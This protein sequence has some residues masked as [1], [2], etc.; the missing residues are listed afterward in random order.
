MRVADAFSLP[1]ALDYSATLIWGV[2]GALVAA[3]RKYDLVG[4]CG[5]A[6]VSA[7]GGGLI[8]DGLFLQQGPPALVQTPWYIA[9]SLVGALFVYFVGRRF[10]ASPRF[11]FTIGFADALG[12]GAYAVIG[13]GKA[14]AVG[15]SNLGVILV[16]LVNA[17]GGGVLRDLLVGREQT[18]FKPGTL[19]VIAALAG[20]VL[21]VALGEWTSLETAARAWATIAVTFALRAAAIRFNIKTAPTEGFDDSNSA[22]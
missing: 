4:L 19:N 10:Y 3:R 9:L 16:G 6:L 14:Q 20:C 1:L 15:M 11:T 22:P 8:R 13:M 21:F 5:M 12:L 18:I 2:S 7:T 17:V